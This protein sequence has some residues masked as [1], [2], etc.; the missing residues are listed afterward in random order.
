MLFG[1]TGGGKLYR[2]PV[3]SPERTVDRP[4]PWM[5]RIRQRV[6]HRL[7]PVDPAV[8]QRRQSRPEPAG[9]CLL[10]APGARS[11]SVWAGNHT[12]QSGRCRSFCEVAKRKSWRSPTGFDAHALARA[13]P[14]PGG[15]ID[16]ANTYRPWA[17]GEPLSYEHLFKAARSD[18]VATP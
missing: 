12:G 3:L 4:F 17:K 14:S 15:R 6:K 5:F 10:K 18:K 1:K 7:L 16:F 13:P 8:R 11:R 9:S 2:L